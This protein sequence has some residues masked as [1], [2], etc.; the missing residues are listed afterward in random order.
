VHRLPEV[1]KGLPRQGIYSHYEAQC[2]MRTY[3][4]RNVIFGLAALIGFGVLVIAVWS[5]AI[6]DIVDLAAISF[7]QVFAAFVMLAALIA[8]T[9]LEALAPFESKGKCVE[10]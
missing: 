3:I 9:V 10:G 8:A 7:W 5:L 6:S 1:R 2:S 4:F